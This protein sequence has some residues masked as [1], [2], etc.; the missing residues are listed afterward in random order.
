MEILDQDL[1]AVSFETDTVVSIVDDAVLN[2]NVGASVSVPAV[3]VLG[4]VA[5]IAVPTD[6]NVAEDDVGAVGYKVIPLRGI[7]EVDIL[8]RAAVETD[9]SKEDGTKNVYVLCI[10]IVPDLTI[11]VK[12]ATAVD[13]DVGASELEKGGGILEDLL[14]SIFLPVVCVCSELYITLDVCARLAPL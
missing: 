11:T 5:A 8:D 3:G 13:I 4:H 9:C 1:C 7:A 14:E 12:S 10:K 2:D 6:C